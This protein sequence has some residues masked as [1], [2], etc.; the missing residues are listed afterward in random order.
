MNFGDW[1]DN[2]PHWKKQ[3]FNFIE[4]TFSAFGWII[5][6]FLS[7]VGLLFLFNDLAWQWYEINIEIRVCKFLAKCQ[8]KLSEK[9]YGGDND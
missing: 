9:L 2:A 8:E 5:L 7:A 4:T 1:C 6:S 3:L